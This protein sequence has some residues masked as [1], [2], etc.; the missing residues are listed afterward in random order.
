MRPSATFVC[1]FAAGVRRP[2]WLTPIVCVSLVAI[3]AFC[4]SLP[5]GAAALS[6][7]PMAK[8]PLRL[9]LVFNE[10]IPIQRGQK[11]AERG[12]IEYVWGAQGTGRDG[13]RNIPAP[14]VWHEYY[15]LWPTVPGG[16]HYYWLHWVRQHHPD[17]LLYRQDRTGL[18]W[19]DHRFT[20]DFTNPAVQR[21]VVK[22]WLLPALAHGYD[23]ISFDHPIGYNTAFAAGHYSASGAWVQQY[24]GSYQDQTYARAMAV[25]LQD[26]AHLIHRSYP[27]ATI[28]NNN[29]YNCRTNPALWST[30][31]PGLTG[32]FDEQ[33]FT[34]YGTAVNPY[35]EAQ[36]GAYCSNQW[37]SKV[38]ALTS[39]DAAHL[40]ILDNQEPYPVSSN[41]TA[42]SAQ[43]RFDLEWA[44][45]NYFLV[46]G[47]QTYF[48]W[49][50]QQQYSYATFWQPEYTA[51]AG[52][53]SPTNSYY[54]SQNVYMRNYSHGLVIVN[55]SL[56]SSATVS[57]PADVYHDLYGGSVATISMPPH[58][59]IVLLESKGAR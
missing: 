17:W 23:G 28:T 44:L 34:N 22:Q 37:L 18:A 30:V 32:L 10:H 3:V 51:V 12:R 24:S 41:L 54:A 55:P 43:A 40:L 19:S 50:G 58:S 52:I 45:A 9:A 57:L 13:I 5:T 56:S 6:K 2:I 53:G 35:I 15:M 27:F 46:K 16:S 39:W 59:G 20:L 42:T 36:P 33:G 48:W 38:Q 47:P 49:G 1:R 29:S 11:W 4:Q 21:Y 26:I 14:G 7:L 8:T 31:L 25:S